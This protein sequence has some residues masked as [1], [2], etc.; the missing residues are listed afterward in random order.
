MVGG[1][2]VVGNSCG[3]RSPTSS[4]PQGRAP[5]VRI[6]PA[7][8]YRSALHDKLHEEVAELLATADGHG[9]VDEAVDV[10]EVVAAIAAEQGATL[11]S[12]V[13]VARRKRAQRGG[14]KMQLWLEGV[15]R[16]PTA[17]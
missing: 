6:L 12:N 9:V 17:P 8:E 14:F 16:G 11:D 15:D 10:L 4:A 13:D 7:E 2:D 1:I 3:T 5:R